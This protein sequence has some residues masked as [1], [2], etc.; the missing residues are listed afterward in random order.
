MIVWGFS[1]RIWGTRRNVFTRVIASS[2]TMT[3]NI[4]IDTTL[5]VVDGCDNH[6]DSENVKQKKCNSDLD[7]EKI[8]YVALVGGTDSTS[9]LLEI[10]RHCDIANALL[11]DF[12]KHNEEETKDCDEEEVMDVKMDTKSVLQSLCAFYDQAII[13]FF[14]CKFPFVSWIKQWLNSMIGPNCVENVHVGPKGF[15]DIVFRSSKH[16]HSVL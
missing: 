1:Y 15:Y 2:S 7:Q 16:H 12:V 3:S 14:T 5:M 10:E 13:L 11:S 9:D 8:S 6:K 4:P